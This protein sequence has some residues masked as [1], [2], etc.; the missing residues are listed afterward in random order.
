MSF[1]TQ[2]ALA[3]VSCH[4]LPSTLVAALPLKTGK[5]RHFCRVL[6]LL[7]DTLIVGVDDMFPAR[8]VLSIRRPADLSFVRFPNLSPYPIHAH[9]SSLFRLEM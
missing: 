4:T 5:K 1:Y 7:V 3:L 2:G 6:E 8:H 9:S